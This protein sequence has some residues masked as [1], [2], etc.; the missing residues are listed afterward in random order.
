MESIISLK[1]L[2][3]FKTGIILQELFITFSSSSTSM[4]LGFPK[5]M[6]SLNKS[7]SNLPLKTGIV[8]LEIQFLKQYR[9]SANSPIEIGYSG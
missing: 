3:E 7:L 9:V 2:S 8:L 1:P 4:S 6:N 5:E